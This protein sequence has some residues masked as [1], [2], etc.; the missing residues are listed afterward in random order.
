[1]RQKVDK[2]NIK[3]A[4]QFLLQ[5]VGIDQSRFQLG[6]TKIFLRPGQVRAMHTPH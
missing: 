5:A 2:D 6:L 4:C 1:L 3:L